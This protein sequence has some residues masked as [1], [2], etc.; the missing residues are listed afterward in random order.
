VAIDDADPDLGSRMGDQAIDTLI[1]S[2][3]N[4]AIR[5]VWS[6]GRHVVKEGAH[7]RRQQILEAYQKTMQRLKEKL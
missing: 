2:K 5:D 7:I 1:F 6:A 3:D 4:S